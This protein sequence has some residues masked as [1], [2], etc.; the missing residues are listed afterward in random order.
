ML[1]NREKV[2]SFSGS[3][4]LSGKTSVG[5]HPSISDVFSVRIGDIAWYSFS[6]KT[7]SWKFVVRDSGKD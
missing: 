5:N 3:S 1:S 4:K 7:T 2:G 6:F